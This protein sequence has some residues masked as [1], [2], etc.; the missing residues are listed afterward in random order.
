MKK[1]FLPVI[2]C[3]LSLTLILSGCGSDKGMH[4][5]LADTSD[6]RFSGYTDLTVI[7]DGATIDKETLTKNGSVVV[8]KEIDG[9]TCYGVFNVLEGAFKLGLESVKSIK[10]IANTEIGDSFIVEYEKDGKT[11]CKI[12]RDNGT[13]VY[14][15]IDSAEFL[16]SQKLKKE[17]Y[18]AWSFY[19]DGF[20]NFEVLKKK[21]PFRIEAPCDD[22]F[23]EKE[24]LGFININNVALK[25]LVD[26]AKNKSTVSVIVDLCLQ[27][28]V[29]ESVEYFAIEDAYSLKNHLVLQK[30]VQKTCNFIGFK[31]IEKQFSS[32]VLNKNAQNSRLL[33]I[34]NDKIEQTDYK[35]ENGELVVKGVLSVT[36]VFNSDG[37]MLSQKELVPFE[38]S[39]QLEGDKVELLKLSICDFSYSD[40]S[41]Y[42]INYTIKTT[43][44]EFDECGYSVVVKVEEGAL[45]KINNLAISVYIPSCGDTLWDISK[46]LGVDEQTIL[47][48][49]ENLKFPLCGDER[50]VIYRELEK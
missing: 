18:E 42:V 16:G 27:A 7:L 22:I 17:Y 21:I 30:S 23:P 34:F 36:L 5:K 47:K 3:I 1:I 26:E 11:L 35:V 41:P 12:V 31:C 2:A 19:K 45:K 50:V 44:G 6:L 25:V 40:G 37:N 14:E 20:E 13:V 15:G 49:N 28:R 10:P 48:T 38:F 4:S 8:S 9:V 24:V 32:E 39:T 46:E 33:C 29:L 43:F